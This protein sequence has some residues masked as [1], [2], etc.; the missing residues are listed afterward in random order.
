MP[1]F[2]K[3]TENISGVDFQYSENITDKP[4]QPRNTNKI[5]EK[6]W[7][8]SIEQIEIHIYRNIHICADQLFML[9]V[10]LPVN[11]ILYIG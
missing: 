2:S 3:H 5:K 1:F 6:V 7:K 11:S 8:E 10:R 9:L 4:C